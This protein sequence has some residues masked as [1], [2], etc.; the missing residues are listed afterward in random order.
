MTDSIGYERAKFW[1]TVAGLI[2]GPLLTAILVYGT[3][4]G[5]TAAETTNMKGEIL[6]LKQTVDK[7]QKD[8]DYFRDNYVPLREFQN[9]LNNQTKTLERI[10]ATQNELLRPR[11]R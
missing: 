1:V 2:L 3:Y 11:G 4:K 8:L 6:Q 5:S 10:E 7:Q 9:Q